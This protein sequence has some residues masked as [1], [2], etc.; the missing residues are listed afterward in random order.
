MD[1]TVQR[2]RSGLAGSHPSKILAMQSA[3]SVW[4]VKPVAGCYHTRGAR[5]LFFLDIELKVE[6]KIWRSLKKRFV[7][8]IPM[9]PLSLSLLTLNSCP[10]PFSTKWLPWILL[11]KRWVRKS[12]RRVSS[13]IDYTLEQALG[14]RCARCLYI[15]EYAMARVQVP[16]NKILYVEASPAIS[17]KSL[18]ILR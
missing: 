17:R 2:I 3:R 11:I 1:P 9:R 7:R 18:G 15:W 13:A 5:H 10:L 8:K 16:F 14:P 12:S 6:K 4:E